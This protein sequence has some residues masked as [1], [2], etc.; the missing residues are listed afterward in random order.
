M[1]VMERLIDIAARQTGIDRIELRRRNL[2]PESMMP[3]TNPFGMVYDS[4]AYHRVMERVLA[5]GDWEGFPAR[6]AAAR[7]RGKCR[8][9]GIANYVDTATGAPRERA[10]ITVKP[11]GDGTI[12]VVIGTVSQGQGHE[13]SFAQ[14]VGEWL[15]VPFDGVHLVTGDTD[16]VSVGGG[17]HSGRAL[18]LG[19]IVMLNASN[20]I[21]E[22]GLR[23]AS[24]LLEAATP[25]L[26][27]SEGAFRVKGTDRAVGLFA[28]ARAAETRTDLP[29][30]LRGPLRGEGD[31]T[32][33][34][35]SFPYGCHVCEVE[36]DPETG[37]TEIVRY[38]AVDDCGRAINPMIVHGQVHGGIVQGVGQAL[39]EQVVYDR[40]SAQLLTGSF[41]DY[42]MPRADLLPFFTTELSE[43]PC[44]THPLGMRPAGE[45]GTTPA[46]G[47][48]INAIVD[49]LAEFGVSHV[50]MPATPERVWR[51]IREAPRRHGGR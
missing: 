30:D 4:G 5:L 35:A 14:L 1:F 50:E 36:V 20:A 9:I 49:A 31:E 39:W 24:H 27:F 37:C 8:G 23:I 22:K 29:E 3:Y 47:V 13:T 21:I 46:L 38:S 18:R 6:R 45:G 2:V 41:M 7:T 15:G 34:L 26:E 32:V 11:E 42:A 28:V 40:D 25:D 10:E 33:N 43:V 19:S 16:R 17:A 44:P 48:V 51:A 12:E